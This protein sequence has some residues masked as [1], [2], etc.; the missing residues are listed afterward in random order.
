MITTPGVAEFPENREQI[1]RN[2]QSLGDF[3]VASAV[4][5]CVQRRN[6]TEVCGERSRRLEALDAVELSDEDHRD[7]RVDTAE[8]A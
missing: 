4:T 5:A 8:A 1:F 2:P 7:C 6:E 3:A